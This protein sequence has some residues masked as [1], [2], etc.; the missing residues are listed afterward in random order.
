LTLAQWVAATDWDDFSS[1]A[2]PLLVS[3]TWGNADLGKLQ[4]GSPCRN[5]GV[6]ILNLNGGGTS[7]ACHIGAYSSDGV[8]VGIRP[9]E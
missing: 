5:A 6:D 3:S 2:N 9:L 8:V 4:A 7:A 1:T